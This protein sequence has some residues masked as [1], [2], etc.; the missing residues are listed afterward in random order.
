M[1]DLALNAEFEV[2]DENLPVLASVTPVTANRWPPQ[3][4]FDLALGLDDQD[5]VLL[6]HNLSAADLDRLFSTAAFQREV[7]VLA[8]EL[9]ENNTTFKYKA[10]AQ[11]ETYLETMDDLMHDQDVPAATKLAIFQSLT[12]LAELEPAPKKAE[13]PANGIV[14][15]VV[16]WATDLTQLPPAPHSEPIDITP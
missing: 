11:A 2:W 4:V 1:N 8:K 5:T 9:H 7:A 12:K 10:R 15:M 3:L 6:R 14:K 16:Q 13:L